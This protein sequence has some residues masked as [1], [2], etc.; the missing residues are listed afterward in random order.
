MSAL[1][2]ILDNVCI[3]VYVCIYGDI[4][5][6]LCV[7]VYISHKCIW[8]TMC[9]HLTQIS[10][11]DLIYVIGTHFVLSTEYLH[12]EQAHFSWQILTSEEIT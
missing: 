4:Y 6:Q 5:G 9:I 1:V 8:S 11:C 2:Y 7:H 10:G 3:C 12:A